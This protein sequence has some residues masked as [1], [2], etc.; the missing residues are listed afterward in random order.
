MINWLSIKKYFSLEDFSDPSFVGTGK[1]INEKVL[2]M[3]INLSMLSGNIIVP[4]GKSGGCVDMDGLYGHSPNSYHLFKNGCRAVDFHFET[5]M[6]IREQFR[7]VIQSG[8]TGIGIYYD[9][10]WNDEILPVGFHVD[11][12]PAKYLQIWKRDQGRYIYFLK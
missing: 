11:N 1:F 8:F 12:R 3:L 4:H 10:K 5:T 6:N 9:W 2:S 7:Y